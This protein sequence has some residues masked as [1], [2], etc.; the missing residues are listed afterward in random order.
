MGPLAIVFARCAQA[1]SSR[2][3]IAPSSAPST[4]GVTLR[5]LAM[6]FMKID[7]ARYKDFD[8]PEN[9]SV[10]VIEGDGS[11][12]Y[13]FRQIYTGETGQEVDIDWG[14]KLR[15]YEANLPEVPERFRNAPVIRPDPA[16]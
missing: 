1:E 16:P 11:T 9:A 4:H 13:S 6:A 3:F 5:T 10:Y 12:Y 2:F 7:P 8:N 15:A 14:K